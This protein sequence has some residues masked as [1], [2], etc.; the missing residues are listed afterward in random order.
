LCQAPGERN[1]Q[2]SQIDTDDF[3]TAEGSGKSHSAIGF[4]T[5][6]DSRWNSIVELAKFIAPHA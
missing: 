1:R 5:S 2:V 6:Y 3:G 4:P